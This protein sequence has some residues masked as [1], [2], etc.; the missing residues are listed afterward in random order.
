[1]KA[2]EVNKIAKI[3]S[4]KGAWGSVVVKVLRY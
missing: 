3:P 1:M 4:E 2:S